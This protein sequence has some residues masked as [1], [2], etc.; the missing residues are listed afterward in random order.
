MLKIEFANRS[1]CVEMK[2]SNNYNNFHDF[3]RGKS[4]NC[5]LQLTTIYAN[6]DFSWRK[7][8]TL[9][10][11][12]QLTL[13]PANELLNLVLTFFERLNQSCSRVLY[14]NFYDFSKIS[15]RTATDSKHIVHLSIR[16]DDYSQTDESTNHSLKRWLNFL[17][18]CHFQRVGKTFVRCAIRE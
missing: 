2:A 4:L 10:R 15:S 5:T 12:R 6:L 3:I 16:D 11:G 1:G 17:H 9:L 8:L 7:S 13:R 14:G 18:F